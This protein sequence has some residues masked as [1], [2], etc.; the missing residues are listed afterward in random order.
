M[1]E[2]L[3]HES[4]SLASFVRSFH[5][6]HN[7]IRVVHGV[8]PDHPHDGR[9][10]E[11]LRHDGRGHDPHDANDADD[12]REAVHAGDRVAALKVDLKITEAQMPVWKKFADALL[13]AAK[14]TEES[15]EGMHKQ[16]MQSGGT[17]NLP[18]K[19]EHHAKMA[20]GHLASL[21]AIKA[22]LEPLYASFSD[23]QKKF[24]DGLKIGPMGMM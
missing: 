14:S 5:R 13:A 10:N 6:G 19:L 11:G 3:G 7:R 18:Q 16:M 12:A 20:A 9:R 22:A 1:N 8:R 15:M 2:E 24:A 4:S 23:E 17:A 21:Q